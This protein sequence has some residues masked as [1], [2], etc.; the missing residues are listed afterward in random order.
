MVSAVV[1]EARR[2]LSL[3]S[4][5]ARSCRPAMLL[6]VAGLMAVSLRVGFGSVHGFPWRIAAQVIGSAWLIVGAQFLLNDVFD[7]EIDQRKSEP[8]PVASGRLSVREAK[9]AI[10]GMTIAGLAL[11]YYVNWPFGVVWSLIAI[12]LTWYSAWVT[13]RAA[14]VGNVIVAA[15]ITMALLSVIDIVPWPQLVLPL[16]PATFFAALTREIALDI[17]EAHV[18]AG[19]RRGVLRAVLGDRGALRVAVV[20]FLL[21]VTLSYLPLLSHGASPSYLWGVSLI[22]GALL[23]M[24]AV[25]GRRPGG[26]T[27]TRLQ[28]LGKLSMVLYL[29]LFAATLS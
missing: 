10:V 29:I 12:L 6:L 20:A 15:S 1:P 4:A 2:F 13:V 27:G 23:L 21:Q 26:L 18:D 9:V 24:L 22:N 25:A 17:E 5:V 8:P 16:A 28:R 11:A 19:V 14:A 3:L 7:R